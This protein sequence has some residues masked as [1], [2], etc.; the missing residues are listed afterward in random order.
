MIK[1]IINLYK[2]TLFFKQYKRSKDA[3]E[4]LNAH[5]WHKIIVFKQKD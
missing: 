2:K 3:G 5:H 1:F 4:R